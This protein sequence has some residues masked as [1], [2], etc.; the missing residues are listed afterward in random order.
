VANEIGAAR[1]V[2]L[3]AAL[4]VALT[5]VADVVMLG[6]NVNES[7]ELPAKLIAGRA[8]TSDAEA[9]CA[10]VVEVASL[11]VDIKENDWMLAYPGMDV[12]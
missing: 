6:S 2:A 11:V 3:D 7:E 8:S 1:R 5:A 4:V 12:V 10:I 9:V